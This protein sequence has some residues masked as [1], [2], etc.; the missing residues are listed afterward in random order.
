MDSAGRL[1]VT[2]GTTVQVFSPDGK[3]L[4]SIPTPGGAISVAFAGPNR[5]TMYVV[6]NAAVGPDGALPGVERTMR[7]FRI[8]SVAQG[9]KNRGKYRRNLCNQA[10]G[11]FCLDG[12]AG[13]PTMGAGRFAQG[14]TN[15]VTRESLRF[16]RHRSD[17]GYR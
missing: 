4:G 9:L 5:K 8:P 1:Y 2:V 16:E 13:C 10:F 17:T 14:T 3:F 11:G 7:A 6:V 15:K 12:N